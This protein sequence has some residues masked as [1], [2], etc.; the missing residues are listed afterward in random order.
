MLPRWHDSERENAF[1]EYGEAA[2]KET[3]LLQETRSEQNQENRN[4]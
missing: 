3:Q 4:Y 2:V 1:P